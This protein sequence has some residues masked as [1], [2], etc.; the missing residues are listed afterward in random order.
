MEKNVKYK[1]KEQREQKSTIKT[2]NLLRVCMLHTT[3]GQAED[4]P[5]D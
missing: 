5:F 2:E 1:K 3:Q 4:E